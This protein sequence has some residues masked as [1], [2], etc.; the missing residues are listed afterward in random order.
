[1]FS[2][3]LLMGAA[4][5]SAGGYEVD[6]SCRFNDDDS[7]TLSKTYLGAGTS[8]KIS[9]IEFWFKR[10]LLATER[11]IFSVESNSFQI[12]FGADDKLNIFYF[13]SSYLFRLHT[14][15]VFR[16]PHAWYHLT[17]HLDTTPSTPSASSMGLLINGVAV[18]AF[19]TAT[20]PS[21]NQAM[22]LGTATNFNIGS[23]NSPAAYYDGY[24]SNFL[25][26]DGNSSS[27]PYSAEFDSNGVW[28]PKDASSAT[29]GDNGVWLDFAV[30]SD[31]GND[32]SG[33]NND[34]TD[35]DGLATADQ[36][37][38]TP[39]NNYSTLS[40]I[41]LTPAGS[42]FG[43]GDGNLYALP[44]TTSWLLYRGSQMITSGKW[45]FEAT[46]TGTLASHAYIGFLRDDH[47]YTQD[48]ARSG[49]PAAKSHVWS[50]NQ[51][52]YDLNV[53]TTS[54]GATWT[55]G[56]VITCELDYSAQTIKWYKNGGSVETT[57]TGI[58]NT[59]GFIPCIGL[60]GNSSRTVTLN[61]GQASY[62][63][64][65]STDHI[66]ICTTN[67]A[68]PTIVDGSV[69]VQ[70]HAYTGTGSAHTETLTGNSDLTSSDIV[71]IKNRDAADYPYIHNIIRTATKY[72]TAG[73][74]DGENTNANSVTSLGDSNAFTLGSGA[75][76]WNDSSEKFSSWV[77]YTDGTTGSAHSVAT[78][79]VNG[80]ISS[81]TTLVVDGN[82]GTIVAGMYVAGTGISGTVT[83]ASLSDQNNLVLSSS[84]SLSNDVALT[85]STSAGA[86]VASTVSANTDAGISLGT[87]TGNG[88]AVTV[89]HGLDS[90]P[91]W[92]ILANLTQ[93]TEWNVYSMTNGL[94]WTKAFYQPG[95]T[96][97]TS[98]N[99]WY[100]T[101]PTDA[102]F[103]AGT[104]N[105]VDGE[106][107]QFIAFHSVE[108]FS[109]QTTYIGNGDADGPLIITDFK[110][111]VIWVTQNSASSLKQIDITVD[112][113]NL[114]STQ[115]TIWGSTVHQADQTD[116][117]ILSNG[118]KIR[119]TSGSV[120][121]D[122]VT[123]SVMAWAENPFGGHGGTFGGG[124][125]PATAR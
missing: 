34:F 13:T 85:F 101:A 113:Y 21:Q 44:V 67:L 105:S 64:T 23:N 79:N 84:Q 25:Y 2:N 83:V 29:F 99:W 125:A 33:K 8:D 54:Q 62:T 103:T 92:I 38:D 28:R 89:G 22:G 17:L 86:T 81:T 49:T 117:D 3:N 41:G 48:D 98:A 121:D 102:V 123:Y 57:S 24:I 18:T 107:F 70:P 19:D 72:V 97:S 91:E 1:M 58:S 9:Q 116:M 120:N 65:P 118:F 51:E 7:A 30:D 80:A 14:T 109:V 100:N 104:S 50:D 95:T 75:N 59:H 56:D 4:S 73:A 122:G 5:I 26:C 53:S 96:P 76:G 90:A 27:T 124:V 35:S 110:P 88:S 74:Y 82:S 40:S 6:Y 87:Y 77:G 106:T 16:D 45:I 11:Y 61:F 63:K 47:P 60:Y 68:V 31:F 112:K 46:W 12:A 94:G 10:G 39:T 20:Y 36:M 15:Q 93:G 71:F 55:G 69:H 108:G 119:Q 42:S 37:T 43:L 32:V 114:A 52:R 111:S 78:A 115:A 66:D